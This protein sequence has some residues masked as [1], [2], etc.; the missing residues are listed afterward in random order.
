MLLTAS[1]EPL[2]KAS[3]VLGKVDWSLLLRKGSLL[4]R[5]LTFCGFVKAARR[6]Q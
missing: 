3:L 1:I 4:W 5:L 6:L 2:C